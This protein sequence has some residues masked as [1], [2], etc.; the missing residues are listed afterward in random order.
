[1]SKDPKH[2]S[3]N[4]DP[5]SRTV[6]AGRGGTAIAEIGANPT[7]EDAYWREH[8]ASRAYVQPG[9]PYEFYQP[10]YRFGWEGHGRYGELNWESAE[11][12][13]HTDWR[14]AGGDSRLEWKTASP[15]VKDAWERIHDAGDHPENI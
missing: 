13:M 9:T 14:R 5:P 1:M 8:Y 11:T 7:V 4:A 12:R 10:A 6:V 2:T 3:A 15:A